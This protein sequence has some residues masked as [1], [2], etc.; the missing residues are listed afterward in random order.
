MTC[1]YATNVFYV[2]NSTFALNLPIHVAACNE[3][4][5]NDISWMKFEDENV[6]KFRDENV[7]DRVT[8]SNLYNKYHH[9]TVFTTRI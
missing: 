4:S 7:T 5:C 6:T 2:V 8:M 9:V 3:I 1:C